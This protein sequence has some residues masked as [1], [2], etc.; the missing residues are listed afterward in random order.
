[1][2]WIFVQFQPIHQEDMEKMNV[3]ERHLKRTSTIKKVTKLLF[4]TGKFIYFYVM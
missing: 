2:D 1:M 4:K 3:T